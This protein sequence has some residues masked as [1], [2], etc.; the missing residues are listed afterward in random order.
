[1]RHATRQPR[2]LRIGVDI[3]PFYEP[4]TGVGWYLYYVLHELAK[5]DDV[6]LVLFGDARVWDIGPNLHAGV[7]A[8]AQ[9]LV[10][11]LRGHDYSR[12]LQQLTAAAYVLLMKLSA[13]DVVFAANYFLPRLHSAVARR[14]VITIHDLTYKRFP[15]LLQKETLENLGRLMQREIA[16]ADAIIC[17]SESTRRD[18]LR[19]YEVDPTR[20]IAILS[21]LG[22]PQSAAPI[23]GLPSRYI[24]FVST[25]E[26]RKNLG[27]LLDAFDELR[28]TGAYDGSLVVVGRI[29]WKSEAIARRLRGAGIVHLDYVSAAQLATVYRN[30][31]AF[32]FPSIY[33]GFGFPLL[34]AMAHGVPTIAARSSSLPEIGGDAALYFDPMRSAELVDE[35][36][37]VLGDATLR[38]ELI[39]RGR[40]QVAK[41][42]WDVAAKKTLDVLRRAAG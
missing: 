12:V 29:G 8:N 23:D 22:T 2:K 42:R 20:A 41:F 6:E 32:V 25:V 30:A 7:P 28:R 10:F 36:R 5:H 35:L 38:E 9:L 18:L 15:E 33:E 34:E 40:E 1:M 26:P 39:R 16:V 27:V 3:R 14:R 4:L 37:R 21:G 11:D 31:E 19:F 24:L 17:V 13:C